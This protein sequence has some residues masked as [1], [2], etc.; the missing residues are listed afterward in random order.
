M[1]WV[2]RLTVLLFLLAGG[3]SSCVTA[4]S[5]HVGG[6][7]RAAH[8]AGSLGSIQATRTD[9]AGE[10]QCRGSHTRIAV[11]LTGSNMSQPFADIVV[12]NTG[13]VAC[14]LRGYPRVRAWGHHGWNSDGLSSARLPIRVRHGI[15]ERTDR[16]PRRIMIRPGQH[17]FFSVGTATAYQGGLH[18]ITIT[19]FAVTL[20]GTDRPKPLPIDMPAT[21][22]PRRKIPVGITAV[23]QDQV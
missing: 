22:P 17:V 23:R 18:I 15:Y 16:G 1:H 10:M 4:P 20:P 13:P 7:S 8:S 3:S 21:R 12:T 11:A 5:S 19:R 14:V 6:P 9:G 2:T